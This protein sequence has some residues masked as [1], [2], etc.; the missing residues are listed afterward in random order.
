MPLLPRLRQRSSLHD[1][2]PPLADRTARALARS[3]WSAEDVHAVRE[4]CGARAGLVLAAVLRGDWP[5][6]APQTVLAWLRAGGEPLLDA[7][8]RPEHADRQVQ[9]MRCWSRTYGELGPL[10]HAAGLTLAETAHLL[11]AGLLTRA[12]LEERAAGRA[13]A[14]VLTSWSDALR[15]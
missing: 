2:Q 14:P 9:G 7:M 5:D 1:L 15:A 6:A 10:A 11:A 4:L 13:P 3:G 12:L 8:E